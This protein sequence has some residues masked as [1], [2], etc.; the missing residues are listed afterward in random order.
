MVRIYRSASAGIDDAMPSPEDLVGNETL[1]VVLVDIKRDIETEDSF[2]IKFS[3]LTK[4]PL[5]K[6]KQMIRSLPFVLWKGKARSK[7][8]RILS[9]VEEAGGKG[10]IERE[11]VLQAQQAE[12]SNSASGSVCHYCGFPIKENEKY[13]AFCM[14]P[15]SGEKSNSVHARHH[16]KKQGIPRARLIAYL[17]IIG[18]G[19]AYI[20]IERL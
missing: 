17:C 4:T 19:I 3:I 6:V 20:I 18:A 9:I 13:C 16:E 14:T 11:K 15:V 10:I 5:P 7:A 1:R 12:K 8:E 2:A